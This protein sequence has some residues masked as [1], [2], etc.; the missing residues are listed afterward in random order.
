MYTHM[1]DDLMINDLMVNDLMMD[2]QMTMKKKEE[3]PM[4]DIVVRAIHHPSATRARTAPTWRTKERGWQ[5]SSK[6]PSWK[7]PRGCSDPRVLPLRK[8]ASAFFRQ[9]IEITTGGGAVRHN[10]YSYFPWIN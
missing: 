8:F 6:R 5:Q 3:G 4:S 10:S 1:M 2:G 7:F 9:G